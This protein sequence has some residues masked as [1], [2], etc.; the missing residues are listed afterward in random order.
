MTQFRTS[1][2][3]QISRLQARIDEL[4]AENRFLRGALQAINRGL[5]EC[6]AESEMRSLIIKLLKRKP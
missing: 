4:K 1:D 2:N 3:T 5:H 6:L